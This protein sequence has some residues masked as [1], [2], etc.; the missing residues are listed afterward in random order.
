MQ[1]TGAAWPGYP[2][3]QDGT[4]LLPTLYQRQKPELY[5]VLVSRHLYLVL[6]RVISISEVQG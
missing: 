1:W 6:F 4:Q 5:E 3:F 2:F